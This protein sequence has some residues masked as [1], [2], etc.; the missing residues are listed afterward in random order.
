[1]LFCHETVDE[2]VMSHV[3]EFDGKRLVA[4]DQADVKLEDLPRPPGE[5]ALTEEQTKA[6]AAWLKETLGNRVAEVKAGDRLV[7]SPALALNADKF[8]TPH[9]RRLMRAMKV[10][11]ADD[12]PPRIELQFNPRHAVIKRL[13][14]VREAKPE[15]AK[16]MAEQVLDNALI[17]AGLLDDPQKMVARIYKLLENV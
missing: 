5:D 14:A 9:M 16:L 12:T 3:H 10:E 1:V 4:A 8:M 11:G 7:E 13:A 2:Y 6:L 17:A 15:L